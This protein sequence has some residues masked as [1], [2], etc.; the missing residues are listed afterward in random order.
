MRLQ[1][2]YISEY[3]NLKNFELDFDVNSFIDVFIGK[4]GTGKSNFFEAL[5]EIFRHLYEFGF[6]NEITFDYIVKYEIDNK[7]ISISWKNKQLMIEEDNIKINKKPSL[8]DNVL[9][10]YSGHNT[11]VTN[12][13]YSYEEA[14]KFTIKGADLQD[15]RKFI[16]IG[17]EYKQLLL[18]VLLLQRDENKARNF[19]CKKLGI[20]TVANVIKI[21]LKR[22]YYA[23]N[24]SF[25][26]INNDDSDRFWKP[27]GITKDFLDKLM[28]C[29]AEELKG[30]IRTEGYF[31]D[32]D[33][34]ILYFDIKRIQKEF[35]D[36]SAQEIFRLFDNLKTLEMLKDI[37][38]GLTLESNVEATT[39]YFSDGQFQLVYIYSIVELFKNQN[40]I[41][42]ID[43]PDCFLHPEWQYEFLKQISEIKERTDIK[44]HILMSSHSAVTLIKH[45]NNKV[46]FF[47]IKENLS[48]CYD[49]PKRVAIKKLSSDLILYSEEEQL[50]SIINTIQIEK[51]P[52]LFTEG[53]TDPIILK[54]AWYKLYEEEMPFIPFYAFRCTYLSQLLN[55]DKIIAEMG[56]VPLFGLFDF[57]EA[58]NQWK[59]I[60]GDLIKD[61]PFKGLVK[62]RNNKEVYALMLP[63]SKVSSIRKQVMKNVRTKE[64]FCGNSYWEIEH[65]FY[66]SSKTKDFYKEETCA[67][68]KII[69]FKS[70]SEKIKFARTIV[71]KVEKE[72]FEVFRPMFEF[73]KSVCDSTNKALP[74]INEQAKTK[75]KKSVRAS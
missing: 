66:G 20:Q 67:G 34:Y 30:P 6:Y 64:T 15:T 14:F 51:K 4:N 69:V 48:N 56:E 73:I 60:D 72:Y 27:K 53:S 65:I 11:K 1:F 49:L 13:I 41:T 45:E 38:I 39:D 42:L 8:P 74:T 71:P 37:T 35:H 32:K 47:D 26:I 44:N 22:P 5:I 7:V 54:E 10:Y 18:A 21:V 52:V 19:I 36:I 28:L 61:D 59:G 70:D 62:K 16:G 63:V 46:K 57:D 58:Y 24:K 68:G 31:S 3:K 55:D 2:V 23:V 43:E 33:E 29:K 9:I 75:K 50:L 25:N 12:L 17:K 40:C